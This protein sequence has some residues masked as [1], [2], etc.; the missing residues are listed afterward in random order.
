ML[1]QSRYGEPAEIW[2]HNSTKRLLLKSQNYCKARVEGTGYVAHGSWVFPP[3]YACS[4]A[5]QLCKPLGLSCLPS[6]TYCFP[7]LSILAA[8]P[9][10]AMPGPPYAQIPDAPPSLT[11]TCST[12]SSVQAR[13]HPTTPADWALAEAPDPSITTLAQEALKQKLQSHHFSK[14]DKDISA[15]GKGAQMANLHSGPLET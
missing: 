1:L 8:A 6:G 14:N 3:F 4:Q 11:C 12:N 2:E 5:Q 9:A 13:S 7:W 15:W 10:L